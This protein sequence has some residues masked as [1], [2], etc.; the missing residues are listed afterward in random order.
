[1]KDD[2]YLGLDIGT[3]SVGWAVTD[4]NYNLLRFNNKDMWGSRIFDEA[5]TAADRR[6]NRSARRRRQRQ[7]RRNEFL[8]EMFASEVAKVDPDFFLRL[9]ES[10][11]C[12][13]DKKVD[14]RFTLFAK[15]GYTDED[16]YK[17]YPTVY[18]L[19]YDLMKAKD[20]K[21]IRLIY[22]A[23]LHIMKS[24]GHFLFEGQEFN[25]DQSYDNSI[26]K[27]RDY[28][29]NMMQ[30]TD[31]EY[32][33]GEHNFKDIEN[34]LKDSRKTKR[35]AEKDFKEILDTKN[36][37]IIGT[38]R[39]INGSK[40][41]LSDI[42]ND[43]TLDDVEK[44]EIEFSKSAFIDERGVYEDALGERIELLD[45]MK[46]IYDWK[47]LNKIM[48]DY[49][50]ISEAKI[51][52]YK[53]YRKEL[54][55]LK[56]I[57][58]KYGDKYE[59]DGKIKSDFK[60][61]FDNP[62]EKNNYATY[63]GKTLYRNNKY[64]IEKCNQEDVNKYFLDKIKQFN[65]SDE[66]LVKYTDL[67]KALEEKE[68][69]TKQRNVENSSIPYQLHL[70]ELQAILENA[71]K[72]YE[73][74]NEVDETG[75]SIKDKII[76]MFKFKI[77]YYIGPLNNYH[78]D[79]GGNAW[80]VRKTNE[81]VMPWNFYEVID[82]KATAEKFIMKMTNKC[83]YYIGKDVLPKD[84][85]LYQEFV[86]LNAINNLKLNKK[87]IEL[88][89]KQTLYNQLF[90]KESSIT[91][92]KVFKALKAIYEQN[93][94]EI[95]DSGDIAGIDKTFKSNL[96]TYVKF[97]EILGDKITYEPYKGIVENIVKWKAIFD[98][99]TSIF[100]EKVK[101][102]YGDKFTEE[103]L[104]KITR[105]NFS[106]WGRLS[107]EFLTEIK[108]TNKETGEIYESIMNALYFTN[109]NLMELLSSQF[110]FKD[111]LEKVNQIADERTD[112]MSYENL[113]ENTYLS[114][115][116]KRSVWQAIKICD[117]ISKIKKQSPKKLFLEMTRE[118]D[119]DPKSS[120][121][122]RMQILNKYAA[123]KENISNAKKENLN[124]LEQNLEERTDS[125][126]KSKRLYLYYLQMGRCAYTG[127]PI[128]L[129]DI[130]YTSKEQSYYDIDH[131]YPRSQTKDDSFNNLVLVEKKSNQI[132][133]DRYLCEF[134]DIQAKMNGLWH[135]WQKM[136]LIS[137]EKL[138]RLTRK[139]ELTD[140]ELAGF[141]NR[142]L[143]E[144][145][146]SVKAVS[147]IIQ[148]IYP[149]TKI[150]YV[151]A[152]NVS[153]YRNDFVGLGEQLLKKEIINEPSS[154]TLSK[155]R[156]L[157][158]FHHA[159]DAYLNIVVGNT[160][161]T[162]FTDNPYNFVKENK[163]ET[164]KKKRYNLAKMFEWKVERNNKVAWDPEKH[165]KIVEKMIKRPTVNVTKRNYINKAGQLFDIQVV[166]K[167]DGLYPIKTSDPRLQK[168]NKYGGYNSV[169]NAY[170][171]VVESLNKKDEKIVE[172][173]SMPIYYMNKIKSEEDLLNYCIDQL[174]LKE[175]KI[176]HKQ[177]NVGSK[178][179]INDFPYYFR[180]SVSGGRYK[181]SVA[182]E[183]TL[184]SY[185][186]ELFIL[187]SKVYEKIIINSK[188]KELSIIAKEDPNKLFNM[189]KDI[190]NYFV[191]DTKE[192]KILKS[193]T[194]EEFRKLG[195][196]KQ[197]EIVKNV[198]DLIL[199]DLNEL[200][201]FYIKMFNYGEY[202]NGHNKMITEKKEE[203][204]K[205]LNLEEKIIV[206][207]NTHKL[208]GEAS[209]GGAD[210]RLL[211]ES[212]LSGIIQFNRDITN[213]N[214]VLVNESITGLYSNK[215]VL[216]KVDTEEEK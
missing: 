142:Q 67:L 26:N 54:E 30:D 18:H 96:S 162:K 21:D 57:F 138:Y 66:D 182:K 187:A 20:K 159:H 140:E 7:L 137:K 37:Q 24:R 114:P 6:I 23:C 107:K 167:K 102:E 17:E 175:P 61:A 121:T 45:I 171:F 160:Y 70:M 82:E 118:S 183:P 158:N 59:E 72:H 211:D 89:T 148:K 154:I 110:T 80:V 79:K 68:A 188:E 34:V 55:Q 145:S 192:N 78:M 75:L 105:L 197:V 31:E 71:S 173:Y 25:I 216:N 38:F 41:K 203:I 190:C 198:N 53:K 215:K 123:A 139:T 152:R 12:L 48:K 177:L 11:F 134:P 44:K 106:G 130:L 32:S 63:T 52:E 84:S 212:K 156:D 135:S 99:G 122:R 186:E 129:D 69:L 191:N 214:V 109:Y 185:M 157:N 29:Y 165:Y 42:F 46:S 56:E 88:E 4:E 1:M 172:I 8:Q 200:F 85:I 113:V 116:V 43:E 161:T 193:Y 112:E 86:V 208:L 195:K 73:F 149:E 201:K 77:P 196:D 87:P 49:S 104:R 178:L 98:E 93:E 2:Y 94:F 28:L 120:V 169:K 150:I 206:I 184:P 76:E 90:K 202:L 58:K 74:L 179:L 47:I 170:F 60:N 14:T 125:E 209:L 81:K 176:I 95:K 3:S 13:E 207:N 124:E 146:Q 40:V 22:L 64:S 131:I 103:E 163:K 164:E 27:L 168:T 128:N 119:R 10:K 132:K 213:R 199:I 92:S 108:G 127:N 194:K 151:K 9:N 126:M 33:L 166:S 111:E 205:E 50:S 101:E 155:C 15:P 36:K 144:T 204:F 117:E 35:N 100:V 5:N 62:N 147:Q 174:E 83:T 91:F 19:R 133:T 153:D 136:G 16:Y 115:G 141:I 97:Y 39:A 210:L 51:E 189:Y 180:S 65:L 143:V 181:Y